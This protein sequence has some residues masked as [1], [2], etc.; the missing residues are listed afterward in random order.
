MYDVVY[1][2]VKTLSLHDSYLSTSPMIYSFNMFSSS[3]IFF[4]FFFND[5]ATTEIYTLSLHDALPI[6]PRPVERRRAGGPARQDA[7]ITL[8]EPSDRVLARRDLIGCLAERRSSLGGVGGEVALDELAALLGLSAL[9]SDLDADIGGGQTLAMT[10]RPHPRAGAGH[11]T[12]IHVLPNGV[13][14][15]P[16]ALYE[17]RPD[18]H[19]LRPTAPAPRLAELSGVSPYFDTSQPVSLDARPVPLWLFVTGDISALTER[20]CLRAYPVLLLE[21]GH[22]AQNLVLVA[23]ALGLRSTTI[24]AFHDAR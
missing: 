22:L 3:C 14:G 10:V 18:L 1:F 8:P 20:Y 23:T 19:A 11:P 9:Q 5:T 16:A 13:P 17:Y 15:L 21:A 7:D 4:F 6:L 24:G 12:R 2:V